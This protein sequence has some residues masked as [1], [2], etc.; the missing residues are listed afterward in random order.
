MLY[1]VQGA[2]VGFLIKNG[3]AQIE[4]T[5]P[6]NAL[7]QAG[8]YTQLLAVAGNK[9][10]SGWYPNQTEEFDIDCFLADANP[11]EYDLLILPGGD[12]SPYNLNQEGETEQF[13]QHFLKLGKPVAKIY[14]SKQWWWITIWQFAIATTYRIAVG[15]YS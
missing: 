10:Q 11:D 4:L 9:V 3:F 8:A 6:R 5:A 7:C 12:G 14:Y 15:H 2:R 1:G 13:L